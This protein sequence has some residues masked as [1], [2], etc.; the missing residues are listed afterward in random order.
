[1]HCCK[2][3]C[4]QLTVTVNYKVPFERMKQ[5]SFLLLIL[6]LFTGNI[7]AQYNFKAIIKD[8]ISK[9]PL[10]GVTVVANT[11][12]KNNISDEEGKLIIK[13]IPVSS[14]SF[15]FSH[16]GYKTKTVLLNVS[17]TAFVTVYLTR[18]E[19]QLS[20]VVIVSSS[21]TESRIENLPTRVEVLGAEEVDEEG[22]IKPGN[23]ISL[24]GDVAGIQTQQTSAATGN[25]DL[26]IQG[27]QGRYTQILRDGMPLFGG[28]SGSFSIM[29][30]PPADIKQVEIIKGASST[31]YGGGAIAGLINLVSKKPEMGRFEK[32]LLLNQTSLNETNANVYLSNRNKSVGFTFYAG[33]N[34]QKQM[35]VDKDGYSDL[36]KTNS[37]FL[38]PRLFLY[39]SSKQTIAIGYTGAF[40]TRKGG[41]MQAITQSNSNNYFSENKS[42]RN[43]I[44]AEWENKIS[45]KTKLVIKGNGTFFNRNITTNVFGMKANQASWFTEASYVT[46][47]KKHDWVFGANF[48]GDNF[49]KQLP[50]STQINNYNHQ[51]TGLFVQ[52]DWRILP[53]LIAEAGLRWDYHNQYGSFVLPRIS[54]LYKIN[55]YFSTRLG[56]GMGYKIPTLFNSEIDERDYKLLLPL[57][58]VKPEKSNGLNWDVNFKKSFDEVDLTINQSFYIT[59]ITSPVT[60]YTDATQHIHFQNQSK[61]LDTKGFETYVQIKYKSADAYIG[62]TYTVA[63]KEYD[64]LQ[65]YLSLSARN[66]FAAVIANEFS[67]HFRAGIEAAYTGKQYLDNGSTTPS[68]LF[69]AAMMRYDLS[70][71][72]IVLNCENLFDYRQNKSHSIV[73]GSNTNPVFEQIWAPLDG[74]VVNLSVQFHW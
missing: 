34:H 70:H 12:K 25:T 45:S 54:L 50:D 69:T 37:V 62:Y 20:D 44:D 3:Y 22:G 59:Q 17:D 64:Q 40:E 51:T 56:G 42:V 26:R 35:D 24:L 30:I 72:T 58:S 49:H 21:R 32:S 33:V 36:P 52:D 57:L 6:I 14:A 2:I 73:S 16:T 71:L 63:K 5:F 55:P 41:L 28:Y 38:H 11:F 29:Q 7:Y 48:S 67:A 19:T 27:L 13:N 23:I 68:Y 31:L 66:K 18:S 39:P 65:P 8:S 9:E 43:G 4:N 10:T 61:P 60:S 1:M 15:T 53:K 74:R 46:K 47:Q